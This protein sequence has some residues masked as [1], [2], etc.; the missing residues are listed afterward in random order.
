MS[1][2]DRDALPK[3]AQYLSTDKGNALTFLLYQE[4]VQRALRKNFPDDLPPEL[5]GKK[6][7]DIDTL[8]GNIAAKRRQANPLD[9]YRVLASL[10][11]NIYIT[12]NP[13]RLLEDA[14]REAGRNPEVMISPW[15]ASLARIKTVFDKE[16][17]YVPSF[18]QPLI[19]YLFGRW[20]NRDSLVLSEDEYIRYLI[21]FTKNKADVPPLVR[22]ALTDSL[23]LFLGFQTED[24]AFRVIFHS[25]LA[26]DGSGMSSQ[27]AH[28]AAQIEPQDERTLDPLRARR[29][30]EKY[31]IKGANINLFWGRAEDYLAGL[32]QK[33]NGG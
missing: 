32:M 29:Y 3:V 15:N 4:A 11:F 26:Q 24:W 13:D 5:P 25:I 19:F 33:R 2:N 8:A 22:E 9:A 20:N 16:P 1:P 28:I 14:L 18:E 30:L 23:L 27:Y 10:P 12:A 21:G 7:V 6:S 31:F 17:E